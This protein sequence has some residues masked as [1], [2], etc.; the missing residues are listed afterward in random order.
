MDALKLLK[1][2]HRTVEELFTKFDALTAR[3]I[4]QRKELAGR[5][6][7]EL[8]VHASIEEQGFY[9]VIR[10]KSDELNGLVLEALEEHHVVKWL[11]FEIDNLPSDA[12]RFMAKVKVLMENVRHHVKEE[13]KDLFPRVRKVMNR[14]E[15]DGLGEE[16]ARLKKVAPTHPNPHASQEPAGRSDQ[17]AERSARESDAALERGRRVLPQQLA[18]RKVRPQRQRGK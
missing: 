3:A 12:E 6:V 2:D 18:A 10:K 5:I 7:K 4:K 1:Q 16:L 14:E 17:G 15:L 8:A 11:I 13:E 9:P